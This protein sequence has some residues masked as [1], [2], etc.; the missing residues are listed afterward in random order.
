MLCA[1]SLRL[2]SA[3]VLNK[4]FTNDCACFYP[5][6]IVLCVRVHRLRPSVR[7]IYDVRRVGPD[8]LYMSP[9]T[10]KMAPIC[11]Q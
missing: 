9:L 1:K 10:A 7:T 5:L 6:K 2:S 11:S 3:S 4:L 8:H